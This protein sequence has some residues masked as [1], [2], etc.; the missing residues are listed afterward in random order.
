MFNTMNILKA[1]GAVL[2]AFLF[3]LVAGTA[4]KGLYSMGSG[5]AAHAEGE[6]E[7]AM[8][9]AAPGGVGGEAADEAPAE[10]VVTVALGEGDA[11]KGEKVFGKCKACHKI[12]GK[13]ATGPHLDG[14]VGRAIGGVEGFAYS[15]ALKTHGD[16][17]TL[18]HLDAYL[19][20]PKEYIPGNKMSFAGLPKPEDRA[21][22]IAYLESLG[23]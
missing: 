4:S 22:L 1:A 19:T 18:E 23:G 13:N 11:A 16:S 21:N 3:F 10:E 17:W 9:S 5:H 12:D 2:G 14:V 8:M 15:D 20:N 6:A 7:V